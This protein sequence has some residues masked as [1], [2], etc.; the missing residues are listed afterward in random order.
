MKTANHLTSH[1]ALLKTIKSIK[2]T[3][4]ITKD[5]E[6][7]E[8]FMIKATEHMKRA[9]LMYYNVVMLSEVK[10]LDDEKECQ[11]ALDKAII[12]LQQ[13]KLY[14]KEVGF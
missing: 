6:S 11:D 7:F 3:A 4:G 9:D 13:A 10:G 2:E 8:D 5:E 1:V 14:A 12:V